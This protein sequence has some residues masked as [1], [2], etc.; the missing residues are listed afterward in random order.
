MRRKPKTSKA[1]SM[2]AVDGSARGRSAPCSCRLAMMSGG[3]AVSI[4][5][6]SFTTDSYSPL[7]ARR[8]PIR[9]HA[10]LAAADLYAGGCRQLFEMTLEIGRGDCIAGAV[11]SDLPGACDSLCLGHRCAQDRQLWP[12]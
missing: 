6:S 7:T 9:R 8:R 5:L 12:R 10:P 11:E 4:A 2:L 3:A 1:A